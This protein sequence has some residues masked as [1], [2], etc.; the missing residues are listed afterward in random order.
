LRAAARAQGVELASRARVVELTGEA[1]VLEGG[2]GVEAD[3]F[4][5]AAPPE[6]CRTLLGGRSPSF[7]AALAGAVPMRAACL[8]V[9]VSRLPRLD[10]LFA[11]GIRQPLYLSIHSRWAELAPAPGA[12]IGLARYLAPEESGDDARAGLEEVLDAVQPGWRE[13]LVEARFFPHLTV[14]HWLPTARTGG[15]AGRPPV[16]L[17]ELPH[18]C[19]AG[20]WVGPEGMLADAALA[21]AAA[22][23]RALAPDAGLRAA[24]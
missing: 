16:R 19:L 24:G 8:D 12:T 13:A 11:L 6:A 10:R 2:R 4:V 15:L 7:E 14:T 3:G 18:V 23:A 22:A 9:A 5:L 1:V 17:P 21:S 20:D